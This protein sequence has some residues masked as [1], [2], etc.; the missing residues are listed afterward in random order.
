MPVITPDGVVGQV[1][2]AVGTSADVMLLT[3]PASRIGGVLQRT[4]TRATVS[5]A[6]NGRELSLDLARREDDAQN[7]DV[8]VT[9]GSDG[10]SPRGVVIGTVHAPERPAVGMFLEATL[11][12]SVDLG[13]VEEV[14]VV[15]MT[16]GVPAASLKGLP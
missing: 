11:N 7:G 6:G 9:A 16:M 10:T 8:V 4:R 13:R 14:L 15:P 5:G 2:R 3:D 12:P 1:V